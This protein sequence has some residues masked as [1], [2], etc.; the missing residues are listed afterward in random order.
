MGAK[1][2]S[3]VMIFSMRMTERVGLC[4]LQRRVGL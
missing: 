4:W 3:C 1:L 2:N